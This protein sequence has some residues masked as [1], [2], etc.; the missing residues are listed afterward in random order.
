MHN[1][2]LFTPSYFLLFLFTALLA[3]TPSHAGSITKSGCAKGKE[4]GLVRTSNG[5][6]AYVHP[7]AVPAFECLMKGLEGARYPI[8]WV[9]GYGCRPLPTSNHPRGLAMDVN[10]SSRDRTNPNIYRWNATAIAQACNLT[11]GAVWRNPDAGHFEIRS[12]SRGRQQQ[13][14]SRRPIKHP[15]KKHRNFFEFLFGA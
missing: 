13:Q 11:H 2:T 9:G 1:P 4:Q 6:G 7:S 8:K 15:R 12:V 14:A 5:N 3:A 10:Q